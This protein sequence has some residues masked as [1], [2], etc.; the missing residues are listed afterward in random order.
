M[1]KTPI[2][3]EYQNYRNLA[4]TNGESPIGKIPYR[5]ARAYFEDIGLLKPLNK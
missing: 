1:G 4:I 2:D 5:K 3:L